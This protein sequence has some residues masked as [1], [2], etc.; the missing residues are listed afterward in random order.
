MNRLDQLVRYFEFL[1]RKPKASD[2]A[3]HR[4]KRFIHAPERS[5]TY[6]KM[7]HPWTQHESWKQPT[8]PELALQ[9]GAVARWSLRVGKMY[10]KQVHLH[11]VVQRFVVRRVRKTKV[12]LFVPH[13][14]EWSSITKR[15]H[16]HFMDQTIDS[17]SSLHSNGRLVAERC[18]SQC[19]R[20][21]SQTENASCKG[22]TPPSGSD[23]SIRSK[24]LRNDTIPFSCCTSTETKMEVTELR[25]RE[26]Q[27]LFSSCCC[28]ANEM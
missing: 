12:V 13:Q 8:F 22:L 2:H 26:K 20:S 4:K 10:Y 6:D 9:G 18:A 23:R 1:D 11:D 27:V 7:W 24:P 19:L 17:R 25:V 15:T 28:A 5:R 3:A 14:V 21:G 16:F